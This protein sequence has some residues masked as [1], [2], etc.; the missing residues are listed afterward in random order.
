MNKRMVAGSCSNVARTL[1]IAAAILAVGAGS[2][3]A[4][5]TFRELAAQEGFGW[6]AG[7]WTATAEQGEVALNYRWELDGHM[8]TI[9][10]KMGEYAYRGMVFFAPDEGKA[11]EVG[12]DNRGGRAKGTWEAE[13]DKVISRSDR[14]NAEGEREKV[15]VIHSKVDARTMKVA[16]HRVSENGDLS[17]EPWATME[18]RRRTRKPGDR[19]PKGALSLLQ[20]TWQGKELGGREGS[21]SFMIS[22]N[23]FDAKGPEPEAYSGRLRPNPKADSKQVDFIITKCT[24]SDYVGRAS[25]AIYKIQGK[26][27]TLAACEPGSS[28]RPN[29]FQAGGEV[30]VFVLTKQ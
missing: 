26:Q 9:D 6:L 21:W 2:A 23:K 5:Q 12:V 11:I 24:F 14:V 13:D 8:V 22:G 30:R 29:D 10:F 15:A 7:R 16:L 19:S 3:W 18:F 25:L 27:L 17:E 1:A 20:G 28:T 4:Q